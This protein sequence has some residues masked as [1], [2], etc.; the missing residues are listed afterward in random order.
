MS[1]KNKLNLFD[2]TMLVVSLIIGMGIFRNPVEVAKTAQ[3][4][5]I[6]FLA[7]ILGGIISFLGGLTYAE[8]GS[9]YAVKGGFYKIF[10]YCYHP[11]FA[12]MVNWM[13]VISNAGAVSIVA[14]VGAE[15]I[16]PV[17]MPES[18]QNPLGIK[19]TSITT[20]AVLYAINFIGI[21][22]SAKTQ[23][24]LSMIKIVMMG[25][26]I[27]TIFGN[28]PTPKASTNLTSEHWETMDYFKALA[29]SFIPIFFTYGGYQQTI[30][31]GTDIENPAKNTPKGIFIGCGLVMF[32]YLA[33]NFAYYKVLGM[34]GMANSASLTSDLA[35]VFFGET[36]SKVTSVL[37][38]ISVLTFVNSS[39]LTNPRVYYA[40]AE[41]GVL[42]KFF[43]KQNDKS[44][45]Q[46]IAL[47]VYVSFLILFLFFADSF[48]ELLNYVMFCDSI[49]MI[50]SAFTIFL[51]RKKIL[52]TPDNLYTIGFG[53]VLFPAI[54]IVTYTLV[55]VSA[56]ISNKE[57]LP[58]AI[59]LFL[60]GLPLYYLMKKIIPNDEK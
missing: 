32:L 12:F 38:F 7:W 26:L 14:M 53:K 57:N 15:Y 59:G 3:T 19:I 37:L 54:F 2:T 28:H 20:I 43:S 47:T 50:T 45:V 35:K 52:E 58:M 51:L 27:L 36:G 21:R 22:L 1:H 31:F 24:V 60:G 9:R 33:I 13:L 34:D 44:Q 25:L 23:N 17:L 55:A 29:L 30:N 5:T 39:M 48:K 41:D 42:P 46:E 56:L 40:M 8:I 4:P 18:L 16:N 11:A 10:S 49:G 6:F